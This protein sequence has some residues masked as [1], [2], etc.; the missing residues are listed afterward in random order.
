MTVVRY[1]DVGRGLGGK[2]P[3]FKRMYSSGLI[4]FL[5]EGVMLAGT[6]PGPAKVVLIG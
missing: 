2:G 3:S 1:R 6:E 4:R 5:S